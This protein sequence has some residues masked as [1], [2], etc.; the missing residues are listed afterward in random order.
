MRFAGFVAAGSLYHIKEIPF[1]SFANNFIIINWWD[2]LNLEF[3]S[4]DE[5]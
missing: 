4:W 2:H 3:S 1:Y 5:F